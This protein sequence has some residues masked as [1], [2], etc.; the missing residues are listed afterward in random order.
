MAV[1]LTKGDK[2][3][4]VVEK[5]TELGVQTIFHLR[6]PMRCRSWM[7]EK[8][9]QAHGALA[10]DCAERRKTMRPHTRARR[11][12]R[13]ENYR[14]F[15]LMQSWPHGRRS[16]FSGKRKERNRCAKYT[17]NTPTRNRC[18]SRSDPEGGFSVGRSASARAQG[19]SRCTFG[20]RIFRAET[21]ALTALTL[22]QFLWGDLASCLRRLRAFSSMH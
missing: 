20:R 15:G 22:V 9:R 7:N 14:K 12:C 13:S 17:K 19:F 2:I 8:S 6:R 4:F 1:A 18:C 21:A 11:C 16:Y 3:D 10:K 5:A